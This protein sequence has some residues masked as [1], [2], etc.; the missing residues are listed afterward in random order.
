MKPCENTVRVFDR[1]YR[2]LELREIFTSTGGGIRVA[3]ISTLPPPSKKKIENTKWTI[4]GHNNLATQNTESFRYGCPQVRYNTRV[5][6][7]LFAI[8]KKDR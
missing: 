1:N 7:E 8:A 3:R 5:T 4:F 6:I 2:L